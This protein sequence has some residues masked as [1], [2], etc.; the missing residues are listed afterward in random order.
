M[1]PSPFAYLRIGL[2]VP[3]YGHSAV[4]RN[5]LKRRLREI[6]RCEL[7]STNRADDLVIWARPPAYDAS[8][9]DL[10]LALRRLRDRIAEQSNPSTGP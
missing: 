3:R 4:D 7:L 6:V 5:R 8:F 9:T 10:Q 2:V 1:S